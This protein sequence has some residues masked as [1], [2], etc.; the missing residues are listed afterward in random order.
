MFMLSFFEVSNG[1]LKKIEYYI[2][3]WQNDQHKKK[4]M[5][6]RWLVFV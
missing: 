1:A 4:Y 2:F 6:V 3:F 5:L